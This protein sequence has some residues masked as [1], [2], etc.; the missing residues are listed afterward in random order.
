MRRLAIGDIHG[1]YLAMLQVLERA[2]FNA[3]DDLLIGLGDYV[4]GWPDSH[5]VVR[6]LMDIQ[7]F[8]GVIG[9]HDLWFIDAS[10]KI[11]DNGINVDELYHSFNYNWVSQGGEATLRSYGKNV[12][13][14]DSHAC[15]LAQLPGY[16]V[17]DDK[18][19]IHGGCPDWEALPQALPEQTTY[20]LAW[21]REMFYAFLRENRKNP[22]D[23]RGFSEC[24]IGHTST[25]RLDKTLQPVS[26]N[27]LWNLDQGGGWEGKLT[28]MDI[29]SHEYWQSDI[30]GTLYPYERGRG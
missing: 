2:G 26:C 7:N 17:V 13:S 20:A 21:D 19:F 5:E 10:L 27:G 22:A 15:F 12:E 23:L 25:S 8:K 29:D 30:V 1:G 24:Y 9:N 16:L 18:L 14:V 3:A 6:Y 4:D 11:R 28:V